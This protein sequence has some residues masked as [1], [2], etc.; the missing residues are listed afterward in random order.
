MKK[1]I[2]GLILFLFLGNFG[3]AEEKIDIKL[4]QNNRY[5]FENF[6]N[7]QNY[8]YDMEIIFIKDPDKKII[9]KNKVKNWKNE[10]NPLNIKICN[11][12]DID[13]IFLYSS[14][15][16]KISYWTK[17]NIPKMSLLK[18]PLLWKVSLNISNFKLSY[19][20]Q[21]EYK[22]AYW[23]YIKLKESYNKTKKHIDNIRWL[24]EKTCSSFEKSMKK[25][26]KA[27][28]KYSLIVNGKSFK[29]S[30]LND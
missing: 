12:I 27:D 1:I 11:K 20:D 8:T 17:Y 30:N 26:N 13:Y 9:C 4:Y 22:K 29:S 10:K 3:F 14:I 25:Y 2:L 5:M 19:T 7:F 28:F 24:S 23:N 18:I 21:I 16:D 6:Y 15:I